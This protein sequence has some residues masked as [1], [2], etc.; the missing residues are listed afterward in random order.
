M[1]FVASGTDLPAF[2]LYLE[3]AFF[4]GYLL[5]SLKTWQLCSPE[6]YKVFIEPSFIVVTPYHIDRLSRFIHVYIYTY[7]YIY[8]CI[9]IYIYVCIYIF[10][11]C[12]ICI[13]VCG[14]SG[15]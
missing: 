2:V 11:G 3:T 15:V 13:E 5:S 14:E 12:V 6:N 8:V 10:K 7:I 4:E 9:Y 1:R